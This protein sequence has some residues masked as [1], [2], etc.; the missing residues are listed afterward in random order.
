MKLFSLPLNKIRNIRVYYLITILFNSWYILGNWIFFWNRYMTYGKIGIVDAAAFAFGLLMEIPT[1]AIA[2]LLGKRISLL[3]AFAF[4]SVGAFVTAF[5]NSGLQILIG[6]LIMQLGFALYS[7]AAEALAYDSLVDEGEEDKFEE[8]IST[9]SQ[10]ALISS[11]VTILIGAPLFSAHFRLPH[12]VWGIAYALGFFIAF[13]LSEP[14]TD[15]E[16]FTWNNYKKQTIEGFNQLK[17]KSLK[18]YLVFF[19]ILLG[20]YYAYDRGFI[21]PAMAEKF[22]LYANGQAILYTSTALLSSV[23]VKFFPAIR[24]RFNSDY[25]GLLLLTL[26]LGTTLLLSATSMSIIG[27]G[28]MIMLAIIGSLASPWISTVVN[29]NVESKYRA[30]TI[31]TTTLISKIP[32][33]VIAV[34][35]G[36][37]IENGNLNY[38]LFISGSF[39]IL[40]AVILYIRSQIVEVKGNTFSR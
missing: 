7:G 27:V 26:V 39:I 21:K 19:I 11:A 37:A 29:E 13:V 1:G 23:F 24:K 14:K 31:S 30:T 4:M 3:L 15:S 5:T 28:L 17:K 8:V 35:A 9:S 36:K 38:L 32:Y 2:D 18:K 10:I 6:F 12:V 40:S 16:T 33:V 25:N 34:I 22:D 20:T